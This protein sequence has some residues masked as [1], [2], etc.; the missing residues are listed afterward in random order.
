MNITIQCIVPKEIP[1]WFNHEM[2]PLPEGYILDPISVT[3]ITVPLQKDIEKWWNDAGARH[4]GNATNIVKENCPFADQY[5]E[6]LAFRES[7][8][9]RDA[10]SRWEQWHKYYIAKFISEHQAMNPKVTAE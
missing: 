5:F 2:E 3:K 10:A 8:L 4:T 7:W 1:D 6:Q 9:Q